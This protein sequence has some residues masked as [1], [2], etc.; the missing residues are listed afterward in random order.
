MQQIVNAL[1]LILIIYEINICL[2]FINN[3]NYNAY[4]LSSHHLVL[5]L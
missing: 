1:A 5:L 2:L 4:L 3:S